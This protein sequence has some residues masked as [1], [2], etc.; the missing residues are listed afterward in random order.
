MN[1]IGAVSAALGEIGI[2]TPSTLINNPSPDA[3]QVLAIATAAAMSLATEFDWQVLA[4]QTT[5]NVQSQVLT[6][7][8]TTG[9]NLLVMSTAPVGLDT[10]WQ[11]IG[12]GIPQDVYVVSVVGNVVTMS[13]VATS[14][15]ASISL[16]F[17]K[18]QYPLPSDYS[19]LIPRTQYDKSRRWAMVGP[20][21]PQEWE[22]LKSSYISTGPRIRYRLWGGY[23]QTWPI[24]ATS[25]LLSFEYISNAYA[26]DASTML[27]KPG[28]TADSD[29]YIYGDRLFVCAIKARYMLQRGLDS[30]IA[31]GEYQEQLSLA[32][33][34]DQSAATLSMASRGGAVLIDL[35]NI[36]DS[37]FGG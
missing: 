4:T 25:D 1:L 11:V 17:G 3:I 5:F 18:T 24:I 34:Y 15:N 16:T 26:I 6:G 30:N 12:T 35:A 9:S 8:T 7:S 33:A 28:F 2:P 14:T 27:R 32:K 29:M 13:Q 19:R 22:W 20:A 37:G 23:L 36:P 10:T 21:T 31:V